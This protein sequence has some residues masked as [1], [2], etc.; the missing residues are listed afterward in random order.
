MYKT[1]CTKPYNSIDL[2]L[3][4]DDAEKYCFIYFLHEYIVK[5]KNIQDFKI[6]INNIISMLCIYKFGKSSHIVV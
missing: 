3:S 5:Y 4:G 6:I 1:T 2:M